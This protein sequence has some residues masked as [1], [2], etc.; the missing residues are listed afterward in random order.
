MRRLYGHGP[1]VF[2]VIVNALPVPT[3]S[4]PA[5]VCAGTTGNLYVTD[6]GMTAYNWSVSAGGTI[7]PGHSHQQYGDGELEH[8]RCADGK[9]ELFERQW[10]YGHGGDSIQCDG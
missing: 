7:L 5:P 1:V 3:L 4:G 9:R 2:P 8:G 10:L 6:A